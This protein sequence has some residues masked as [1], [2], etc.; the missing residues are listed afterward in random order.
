MLRYF[1]KLGKMCR[2]FTEQLYGKKPRKFIV[3]HIL[4]TKF[5]FDGPKGRCE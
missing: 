4:D 1:L 2:E 5:E 3:D